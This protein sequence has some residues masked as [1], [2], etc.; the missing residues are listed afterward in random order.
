[1]KNKYVNTEKTTGWEGG[2]VSSIPPEQNGKNSPS[3]PSLS[4]Q[5]GWSSLIASYPLSCY[6]PLLNL[7]QDHWPW[8]HPQPLPLLS[9][10][11]FPRAQINEL[12]PNIWSNSLH[13]CVVCPCCHC[14]NPA[15]SAPISSPSLVIGSEVNKDEMQT[16]KLSLPT[17]VYPSWRE[18]GCCLQGVSE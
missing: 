12:L 5:H 3:K 16:I 18:W 8:Y 13:A 6:H 2:E 10:Q 15:S 11:T 1:M 9:S 7:P 14:S 4:P 17:N